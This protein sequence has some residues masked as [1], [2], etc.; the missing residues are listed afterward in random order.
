MKK[1][2]FREVLDALEALEEKLMKYCHVEECDA[3]YDCPA[4]HEECAKKLGLDTAIA[5]QLAD[6]VRII[7]NCVEVS[8]EQ[9]LLLL[10]KYVPIVYAFGNVVAWHVASFPQLDD[11][12]E[13]TCTALVELQDLLEEA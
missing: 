8:R 10:E 9:T 1:E 5:W 11:L 2:R 7:L 4:D 13:E 6:R 3:I 12:V